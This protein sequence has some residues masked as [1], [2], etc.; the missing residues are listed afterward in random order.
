MG[1]NARK[2]IS[3]RR[4]NKTS[5]LSHV[6][7]P[8]RV[9]ILAVHGIG[10]QAPGATAQD[11]FTSL[12]QAVEEVGGAVSPITDDPSKAKTTNE[13][14]RLGARFQVPDEC[15]RIVCVEEAWWDERVNHAKAGRIFARVF[16]H[17]PIFVMQ[18]A[19]LWA[20][21]HL[22]Y[23]ESKETK[24]AWSPDS[25]VGLIKETV[26]LWGPVTAVV[27]SYCLSPLLVL[28]FVASL[29]VYMLIW[30]FQALGSQS[31][32]RVADL[33][34]VV[35]VETL[36]DIWA[37]VDPVTGDEILQFVVQ[38]HQQMRADYDEVILVGHS[39]GA[40]LARRACLEGPAPAA[41]VAVGSGHHQ[42]LGARTSSTNVWLLP[43][44]W[45]FPVVMPLFI[46]WY[47]SFSIGAIGDIFAQVLTDLVSFYVSGEVADPWALFRLSIRDTPVI[48]LM[49]GV[50]LAWFFLTGKIRYPADG[51]E[52]PP[53]PS[54]IVRSPWDPVSLGTG[55]VK[56][57]VRTVTPGSAWKVIKEHVTYWEKPESGNTLLEAIYRSGR[58][59]PMGDRQ[60]RMPGRI[61]LLWS[62][63]GVVAMTAIWKIG[64]WEA[65]TFQ[66]LT[67]H[68]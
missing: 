43:V 49:L 44:Y 27:I 40:D 54:W 60:L 9:G 38:R 42:L 15:P 35:V 53:C 63:L 2:R 19:A 12:V 17:L 32:R 36:G 16:F 24:S 14:P 33:I 52:S 48:L 7:G 50:F 46:W 23:K 64:E 59:T 30:L 57:A 10:R 58:I 4:A 22:S 20:A 55:S 5:Q 45:S 61:R 47:T 1:K 31:A 34:R 65:T 51:L 66:H 62:V 39:Q 11:V 13:E 68:G 26:A 37:Y 6:N 29:P 25:M 3:A 8:I 18:S 41:Y 21:R 56:E 67:N 28:L